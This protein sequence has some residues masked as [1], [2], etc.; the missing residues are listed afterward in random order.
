VFIR[1]QK[2]VENPHPTTTPKLKKFNILLILLVNLF[3]ARILL[4]SLEYK[5]YTGFGYSMGFP[6]WGGKKVAWV[7]VEG[8]LVRQGPLS[9]ASYFAANA[10]SFSDRITKLGMIV[11]AGP[12]CRILGQK[13]RNAVSRMGYFSLRD[14]SED[15]I[16]ILGK[17]YFENILSDAILP[18]G[19]QLV[20]RLHREGFEIVLYSEG[21]GY[22]LD[23]LPSRLKDISQLYCNALEFSQGLATGKLAEPILGGFAG[24]AFLLKQARERNCDLAHS[25]AYTSYEQDI[26][27]LNSVGNPCAVNPSETLRREA[28]QMDWPILEY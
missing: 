7:R 17:E 22:A 16:F 1:S 25:A 9:L 21:L 28:R 8:S 4:I 27:L 2:I 19:R 10:Q 14:M 18:G 13:D 6:K 23:Y 15:R 24:S 26:L 12:L 5:Y 3:L 20:E 11:F